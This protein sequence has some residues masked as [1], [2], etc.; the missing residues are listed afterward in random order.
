MLIGMFF[1]FA[2][3]GAAF[4]GMVIEYVESTLSTINTVFYVLGLVWAVANIWYSWRKFWRTFVIGYSFNLYGRGNHHS[5]HGSG[6]DNW[7]T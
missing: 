4:Y 1:N 7:G 2:L 5:T 6:Y 3:T